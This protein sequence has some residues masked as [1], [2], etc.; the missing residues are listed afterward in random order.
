MQLGS[1]KTSVLGGA[2]PQGPASPVSVTWIKHI[3]T[4]PGEKGGEMVP[5]GAGLPAP[6][7]TGLVEGASWQCGGWGWESL[8]ASS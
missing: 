2:V 6:S 5:P 8:S 3:S 4:V 7:D 1:S